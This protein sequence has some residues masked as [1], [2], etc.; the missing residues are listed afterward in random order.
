M[1]DFS[2]NASDENW[3][4][5]LG[6][7]ISWDVQLTEAQLKGVH[8]FMRRKWLSSAHLESP[9]LKVSW[10][11]GHTTDDDNDGVMNDVDV[12]PNTPN[13]ETVSLDGCSEIQLSIVDDQLKKGIT[14]YPNPVGNIL[15]IDSKIP[16]KKVEIFSILGEKL[17]EVS[18]NFEAISVES[19]SNGIYLVRVFS[20]ETSTVIK[21]IKE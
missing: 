21:L 9:K 16:L 17:I 3:E 12:C 7:L 11:T 6:E 2:P 19:L 5:K 4:G 18:S 15:T 14:F 10:G 20:E 8:E 13:G 1:V